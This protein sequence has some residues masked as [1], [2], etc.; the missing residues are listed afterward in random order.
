MVTIFD[1]EATPL[2]APGAIAGHAK[3]LLI[4]Y[5]RNNAHSV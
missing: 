5:F 2:A 4:Q 1:L 3:I